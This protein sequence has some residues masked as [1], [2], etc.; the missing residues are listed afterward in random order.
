[1]DSRQNWSG[2]LRDSLEHDNGE[3]RFGHRHPRADGC[4]HLRGMAA[5]RAV[6]LRFTAQTHADLA[7]LIADIPAGLVTARPP[8]MPG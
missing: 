2:G 1:M 3:A 7:P 6:A 8:V 4:S 5:G